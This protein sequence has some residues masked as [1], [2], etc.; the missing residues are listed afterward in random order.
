VRAVGAARGRLILSDAS[1]ALLRTKRIN[2]APQQP[3]RFS[4]AGLDLA[5][6]S[7]DLRLRLEPQP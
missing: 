5:T 3:I 7:S 1:G 6:D 4:L 2:A